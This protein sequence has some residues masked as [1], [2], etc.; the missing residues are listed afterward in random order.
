M[1]VVI[2]SEFVIGPTP[3]DGGT[4]DGNNPIIGWDSIVV[5]GTIST[6]TEAATR[7]ATNLANPSTNLRWVGDATETDEYIT[8]LN[9]DVAQLDYIALAR[10]NLGS[11]QIPVSVEYMSDDDPETW[12]ELIEPVILQDDSPII[13][14]FEKLAYLGIRIRMQVDLVEPYAAVCYCG[15]LLVLQRRIYVGHQPMK[16]NT[17]TRATSNMSESGD[18][19]GRIVLTEMV[20]TEFSLINLTPDWFRSYM[21]PFL[22]FARE[23]P[24]FVAWRP[25]DYPLEC[26][27]AWLTNNPSP[28]NQRARGHMQVTL[29]MNGIT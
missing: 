6:T 25:G 23:Y 22:A 9:P 14:R 24:F 15:E 1:T 12:V 20:S 28:Q 5:E 13:F 18:F 19:L 16:L 7:P 11:E 2:S 3:T 26:G 10:H 4:I 17:D 8:V 27:F 29:A 21:D